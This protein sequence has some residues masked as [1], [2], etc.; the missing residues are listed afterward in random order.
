MEVEATALE[1]QG[2]DERQ[3]KSNQKAEEL[4]RF[5]YVQIRDSLCEEI[6]KFFRASFGFSLSL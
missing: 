1:L 6:R 5:C 2:A 3:K 4:L